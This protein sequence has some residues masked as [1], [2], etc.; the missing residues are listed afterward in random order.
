MPRP[1][2]FNFAKQV[3]PG[4]AFQSPDRVFAELRGPMR[5][6]FLMF[7]WEETGRAAGAPLPHVDTAPRAPGGMPELLALDVALVGDVQG[8]EVVIVQMPPA[9]EANEAWY[10]ALTRAAGQVRVFTYERAMDGTA[11]LAEVRRDGR[12]NFGSFADTSLTGLLIALGGVLQVPLGG[13]Q[14]PTGSPVDV[15]RAGGMPVGG[16]GPVGARPMSLPQRAPEK[17]SPWLPLGLSG[18]FLGIGIITFGFALGEARDMT[19]EWV[20]IATPLLLVGS[21]LLVWAGARAFGKVGAAAGAGVAGL[22]LVVAF[23]MLSGKVDERQTYRRNAE[24]LDRTSAFCEGKVSPQK[25]AKPYAEGGRNT[26]VVFERSSTSKGPFNHSFA[27]PYRDW[28]PDVYQLQNAAL[29]A[30]LEQVRTVVQ[31]CAY[32]QGATAERMKNDVRVTVFAI[33]TG[34]KLLDQTL[35][36]ETPRGCG[37]SEEFYGNSKQTTISGLPPSPQ[38]VAKV[39]EPFVHP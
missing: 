29:I 30:C 27:A 23:V 33:T 8:R 2:H 18:P 24:A 20:M 26:M 12:A 39:L 6:P 14:R 22:G 31:T 1:H 32:E 7:L 3:L 15:L 16:G 11:V 21:A 37:F 4:Q 34:D 17:K 9:V 28:D 25:E 35:E 19:S 36:G 5:E 38:E 13:L 10:V